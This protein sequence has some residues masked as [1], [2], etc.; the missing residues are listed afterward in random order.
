M[1]R[2]IDCGTVSDD[3]QYRTTPDRTDGK[4]FL[5][6]TPCFEKRLETVK[7]TLELMSPTPAPWFDES[8]AG[9]RWDED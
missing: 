5:R 9:E 6:C 2:C 3:V 8:Y 4:S 1:P 7:S